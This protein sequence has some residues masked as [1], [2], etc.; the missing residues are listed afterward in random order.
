MR[1]I[2]ADISEM[3]AIDHRPSV[4]VETR[5]SRTLDLYVEDSS[6]QLERDWN[7]PLNDYESV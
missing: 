6:G 2:S 1:A 3:S 5:S 7:A 4:D